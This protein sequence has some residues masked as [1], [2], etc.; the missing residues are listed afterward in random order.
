MAS[1]TSP[2]GQWIRRYHSA[3]R[4]GIRLV[5]FPHAGG[6]PNY[7]FPLSRAL[8]PRVEVLAVQYPGR[9]DRLGEKPAGS[10]AELADSICGAL[11]PW[12]DGH[13]AFFGHSMGAIVAFEVARRF[14]RHTPRTPLRLL[15]SGR[16]APARPRNEAVHLRDDAGIVAEMRRLGGT[17]PRFLEDE[18]WVSLIL[19]AVRGDYK[20]IETYAYFPGPPLDCPVTALTGDSDP[21]VTTA[22]LRAWAGHCTGEFELRTF[23]G[24]HFY[25]DSCLPEVAHAI[26]RSLRHSLAEA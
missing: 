9:Q 17:S 3:P 4:G 15:V 1:R 22:D 23:P 5:C 18:D 10:V 21:E 2:D 6:S 7:Y 11:E 12:M 25:M 24:G 14:Q 20:A 16:G 13:A 19:P 26:S 8:A